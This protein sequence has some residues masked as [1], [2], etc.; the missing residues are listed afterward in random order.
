MNTNYKQNARAGGETAP[1]LTP[2][3]DNKMEQGTNRP[4]DAGAIKCTKKTELPQRSPLSKADT[5][6]PQINCLFAKIIEDLK[7]IIDTEGQ[8][9]SVATGSKRKRGE[10]GDQ[11]DKPVA[12]LLKTEK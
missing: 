10:D 6:T 5:H 12:K 7:R 1:K 8:A 3:M 11:E 9:A 2:E 4:Y